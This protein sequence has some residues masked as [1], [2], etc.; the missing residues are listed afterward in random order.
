MKILIKQ[1]GPQDQA[2]GQSDAGTSA[3]LVAYLSAQNA[4][5]SFDDV[6]ANVPA[7]DSATQGENHQAVIDCEFGQVF[8]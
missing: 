3:A 1:I 2:S 5:V 8:F 6:R 4:P 7:L